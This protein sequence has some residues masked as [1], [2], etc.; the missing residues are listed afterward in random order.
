MRTHQDIYDEFARHGASIAEWARINGFSA[1][2]VYQVLQGKRRCLR[3]QAHQ[4]AVA[5]GIKDGAI[6][7]VFHAE[8]GGD[9]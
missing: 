9:K 5:L 1:A 8:K 4:I 2:V 7:P 3:G 6:G